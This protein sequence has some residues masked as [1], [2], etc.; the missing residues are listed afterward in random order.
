MPESFTEQTSNN[1]ETLAP[2]WGAGIRLKFNKF[3]RTNVAL[4]YGFG[5]NGS[6]GLFVNIGE[7]F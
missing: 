3:S 1:F 7:V 4:D 5:L 2:G 6:G